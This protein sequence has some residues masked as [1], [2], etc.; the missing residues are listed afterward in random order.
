[1]I[2]DNNLSAVD[3]S[4]I[5]NFTDSDGSWS[6]QLPLVH[7]Y[8]YPLSKD[9]FDNWIASVLVNTIPF[10]TAEEIES[11]TIRDVQKVFDKLRENLRENRG[12]RQII[13]HHQRTQE[14]SRG[15]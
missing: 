5:I 7:I 11:A 9:L 4:F 1:V 6:R 12:V 14:S 8:A 15:F 3:S 13:S 10:S 2:T